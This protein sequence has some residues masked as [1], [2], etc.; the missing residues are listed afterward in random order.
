MWVDTHCHLTYE[1][2]APHLGALLGRAR[3]A[4]VGAFVA[5]GCRAQEIDP[6]ITLAQTHKDVFFSAGIHPHEAEA[7]LK[8]YAPEALYTLLK[9][10]TRHPKLLAIGETGLDYYYDHSPRDI[11]K[12]VFRL[13]LE[14]ALEKDLPVVIHTRN[15]DDDTIALLREVGQGRIR[16]VL[17]CFSGTRTLCEEGLDLGPYISASG[18]VT[19]KKS[20]DLRAIFKDVPLEKLLLET[21]APYLAPMPHRGKRNE[22]GF[23]IHT[24]QCMADLK[25]ISM[26][27]LQEQT[28]RNFFTLFTKA[29]PFYLERSPA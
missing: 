16:G 17:H 10:A 27:T 3:E 6:L 15:A 1:D 2:D 23:M 28:T 5:I 20:D 9:H 22:S 26:E 25:N 18:I 13:Q 29:Q 19:F 21:D 7:T 4:G 14:L 11:Q 12:D 24:A 8:E